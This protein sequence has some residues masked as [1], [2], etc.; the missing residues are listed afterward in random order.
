MPCNDG[1]PNS[2]QIEAELREL[3]RKNRELILRSQIA[4]AALTFLEHT[5]QL[6]TL[7][8]NTDYDEAGFTEK[9]LRK[10]WHDHKTKDIQRRKE[11]EQARQAKIDSVEN[12]RIK[13]ETLASLTPEQRRALGFK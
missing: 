3:K 13:R 6:E 10:W 11:E 7:I 2:E 5:N 9:D 12:K 1:G 4:C 8:E